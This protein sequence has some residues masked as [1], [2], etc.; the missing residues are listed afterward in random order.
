M[1]NLPLTRVRI[2]GRFACAGRHSGE[3][4]GYFLWVIEDNYFFL[5]NK[6]GRKRLV[7]S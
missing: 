1:T 7:R 6:S 4:R 5:S 2:N 3:I